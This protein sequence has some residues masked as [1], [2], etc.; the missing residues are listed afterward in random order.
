MIIRELADVRTVDWGNGLSRRF[1]VESDGMG[2][3]LTDTI[4]R[5]GTKSRLE[6]RN[7]LE[8]C[9]CVEGSGEVV[10]MEGTSHP[11]TPGV[12]YA[13]DK[14]DAHFLIASPHEDL[15]LVCVFSPALRGDEVH[16]L[17]GAG[18]SHY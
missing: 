8:A 10:D 1:L 7:H 15:R 14:H 16:S 6:Y 17:D 9:Y 13:L 5:A 18:F 11:I 2:Y 12:L 3:T 4:V